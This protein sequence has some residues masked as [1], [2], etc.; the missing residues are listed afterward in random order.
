MVLLEVRLE[1]LQDLDG[2]LD[3]RFLDVDLLEPPHQSAIL[4]E[5][6]AVFLVGG[7]ADAAHRARLQRR[8]EQVGRVHGAAR[9]G[10]GA[11]HRVDLVDE[12]DGT[13]IVLDL[14]HD[15][16]EALLEVA[17]VARAGEQRA[18]VERKD[19]RRPEHFGHVAVDDLARQPFGDRRLAD[20]GIADEQRVV[21]LAPAQHLDGA[22]HLRLAPDQGI[23]LAGLGLLVEVDAVGVERVLRLLLAVLAP[24]RA[25][26]LVDA[27]HVLGLGHAGPLGDAVADVLD[28]L[29]TRHL[30]LLQEEGGV[31]LALGKDGDQHIGAGDLFAPRRLHVH[32]GAVHDALEAGGGRRLGRALDEQAGELVVEIFGDALAQRVEVDRGTPS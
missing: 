31:A 17:A 27:A 3:G 23:D 32:N 22:H 1:T 10:A 20:A 12:Q 4:L 28:R 8:L 18:H 21:L 26:V 7:G 5:V 9:G 19:G 11:D 25:L 30:L 13:G 6:L 15:R 2:V 14:L 16:L 24:F 29:E